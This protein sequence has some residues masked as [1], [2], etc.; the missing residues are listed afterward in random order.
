LKTELQQKLGWAAGIE[1]N[2][3]LVRILGPVE[4]IVLFELLI[5]DGKTDNE[6][7][8]LPQTLIAENTGISF[9]RQITTLEKLTSVNGVLTRVLKGMP[10]RFYYK[11]NYQRIEEL[12]SS[13]KLLI[14]QNACKPAE[15][16]SLDKLLI[17]RKPE[18]Q[19]KSQF[20]QIVN[21]ANPVVLTPKKPVLT[22]KNT[23]ILTPKVAVA[24]LTL[25]ASVVGQEKEEKK[26]IQRKEERENKEGS[27]YTNPNNSY[28][29]IKPIFLT[30]NRG[31]HF[32]E[33]SAATAAVQQKHTLVKRDTTEDLW[34]DNY[35][36]FVG[37][38]ETSPEAEAIISFWKSNGLKC[39]NKGTKGYIKTLQY[40]RAALNG[41]LYSQNRPDLAGVE[42][43][44]EGIKGAIKNFALAA[45]HPEYEPISFVK[46]QFYQK[47][48]LDCF[49]YQQFSPGD[50][51]KRLFLTFL[52][53]PETARPKFARREEEGEISKVA[54]KVL[55]DWFTK[56]G[57]PYSE[58]KEGEAFVAA[59]NAIFRF[60]HDHKNDLLIDTFDYWGRL[61][62]LTDPI[63][64][65]A[66][67]V[68]KSFDAKLLEGKNQKNFNP[69]WVA[70]EL[71]R[72]DYF[73]R[74]L[75]DNNILRSA[76]R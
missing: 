70:S 42:Y 6:W 34:K 72:P 20:R 16:C 24:G 50:E 46:K 26:V 17:L 10:A 44:L 62:G 49:F 74:Y 67:L 58:E 65:M 48:T 75:K 29:N 57:Y 32:S 64:I 13:N 68:T 15:N 61:F 63:Q 41:S 8:S 51:N 39:R 40:I 55:I 28:S 18:P 38:V 23:V 43:T 69:G 36:G 2:R 45:F 12:L 4:A 73:V 54:T 76:K 1:E 56:K 9:R 53:K 7:F 19:D 37:T 22:L 11:I 5:E 71:R 33:V 14:Q 35:K 59:S 27:N 60:Y 47:V 66:Q 21:T 25:K 3:A 31:T 30:E 52:K